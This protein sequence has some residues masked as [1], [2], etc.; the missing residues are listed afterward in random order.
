MKRN[1]NRR[2]CKAHLIK[3]LV[4]KRC[5]VK[6]HSGGHTCQDAPEDGVL[7]FNIGGKVC[8]IPNHMVSLVNQ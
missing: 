5:K 2:T 7:Q 6:G 4:G 1:K 8:Q 3:T